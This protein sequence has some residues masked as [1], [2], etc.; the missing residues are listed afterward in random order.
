MGSFINYFNLHLFILNLTCRKNRSTFM[1]CVVNMTTVEQP[2]WFGI[3]QGSG[4]RQLTT[5]LS[6][7]ISP[8]TPS[9]VKQG[10]C[11]VTSRS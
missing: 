11:T 1:V 7:P 4:R 6:G 2:S 10:Q 5:D 9:S 8:S 3:P